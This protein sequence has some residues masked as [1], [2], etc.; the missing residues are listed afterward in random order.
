MIRAGTFAG[1]RTEVVQEKTHARV[2]WVF[3][4]GHKCATPCPV[5][6][7]FGDVSMAMRDLL[8]RMG[9]KRFN[10]GTAASMLFLN[11]TNP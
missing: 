9:K 2:A 10:P 7:D 6:I 3:M 1:G 11:A 4:V 8:R 5:D